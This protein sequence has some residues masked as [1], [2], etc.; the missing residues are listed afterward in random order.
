MEEWKTIEEL[1]GYYS[2]SN[3]G[4]VKSNDRIINGRHYKGKILQ[5]I[6][7]GKHNYPNFKYRKTKYYIHISVAKAFPEICGEWFEG[8]EVHHLD[9]NP[10]N[11]AAT[12]LRVLSKK[13]HKELH[14][15]DEITKTKQRNAAIGRKGY[16]LG[17][18]F[19][20]DMRKKFS[21]AGKKRYEG[22]PGF[23][24]GHKHTEEAKRKMSEKR[25][26]YYENHSSVRSVKLR[27]Y[28]FS[29]YSLFDF[30]VG[31]RLVRVID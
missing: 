13:E 8:A 7:S 29:K 1:N 12:N 15:T 19:P 14:K 18:T 22:L 16:W 10:L 11:N 4:R 26:R 31:H 23:F 9:G 21:E 6:E 30:S 17:K 24:A 2:I 5:P 20:P 25:K 28:R 3:V 27:D